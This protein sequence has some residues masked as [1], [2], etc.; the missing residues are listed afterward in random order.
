MSVKGGKRRASVNFAVSRVANTEKKILKFDIILKKF[1]KN[2]MFRKL[3]SKI[4]KSKSESDLHEDS[5]T[6]ATFTNSLN[7]KVRACKINF[8]LTH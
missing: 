4:R 1:H 6:V 5:I 8:R 2:L 7:E 3:L